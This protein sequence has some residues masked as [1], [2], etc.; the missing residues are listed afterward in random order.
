MKTRIIQT[1]QYNRFNFFDTNRPIKDSHVKKLML[2]IQQ[3]GLLE[4]ITVNENYDIIDGQHRYMA[5]K[6]LD[7]PIYAKVK[8]GATIDSVLP[9]NLMRMGW[10]IENFL[11]HY[12]RKGYIDYIEMEKILSEENDL[13]TSATIELYYSEKSYTSKLFKEGKYKIDIALGNYIKGLLKELQPI[14]QETYNQKFVRA[15]SRIIRRNPKNY[16]HKRFKKII[17]KNKIH[18]FNNEYD[19]YRNMIEIYNRKLSE[20]NRIH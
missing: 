17:T 14:F 12:A 15:F 8:T 5:L 13:K 9:S 20:P 18:L 16:D 19:T 7:M 11:H 6:K 3:H 4:E 10:T 1:K 2:S